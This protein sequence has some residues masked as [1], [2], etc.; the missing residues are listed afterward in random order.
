MK[1]L[2]FFLIFFIRFSFAKEQLYM[3]LKF[4]EVNFRAG[5]GMDFPILFTYRL[6][7]SPIKIVGEYDNWFKVVDKD[8]DSG[9]VSEHLLSKFRSFITIKDIQ[10]IYS[11]HKK[12]AHPIF[13]IENNITGKLIKCKSSRCKIKVNGVKGWIDRDG[14]WG[15]NEIE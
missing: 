6:K 8:G 1:F 4:N 13:K 7:Y 2:I 5:P 12:N 14:I 10:Y 9:W 11:S 3:S 15:V